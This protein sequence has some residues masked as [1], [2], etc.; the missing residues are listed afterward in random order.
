MI[1]LIDSTIYKFEKYI[2]RIKVTNKYGRVIRQQYKYIHKDVI[3]NY[4]GVM[5]CS[6]PNEKRA[7]EVE[8]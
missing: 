7:V 8:K 5:L 2:N 4:K 3:N 1:R 6:R